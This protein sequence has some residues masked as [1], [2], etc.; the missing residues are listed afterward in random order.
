MKKISFKP[1]L[2]E[3]LEYPSIKVIILGTLLFLV[4]GKEKGCELLNEAI[5]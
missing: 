1:S 5:Q 2:Y 3:C 4:A